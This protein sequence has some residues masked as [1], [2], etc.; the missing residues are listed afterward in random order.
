MYSPAFCMYYL[1]CVLFA[2][3]HVWVGMCMNRQMY[4]AVSMGVRARVCGGV[5]VLEHADD[6]WL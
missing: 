4:A 3:M 2:Y 1:V 5:R 6:M